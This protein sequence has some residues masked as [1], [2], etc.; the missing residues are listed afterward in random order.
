M[1]MI[2]P[3]QLAVRIGL[4][5]TN[6]TSVEQASHQDINIAVETL[7]SVVKASVYCLENLPG[8]ETHR[9]NQLWNEYRD[10]VHEKRYAAQA[11]SGGPT[12]HLTGH[13]P[14]P[15]D[16][17]TIPNGKLVEKINLAN[18]ASRVG[19]AY[20]DP[21]LLAYKSS[22]NWTRQHKFQLMAGA[23]PSD[24]EY[25]GDNGGSTGIS[26]RSI[27]EEIAIGLCVWGDWC[28]RIRWV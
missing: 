7:R 2:T 10:S 23:E 17:R 14:V 13:I 3:S 9:A 25:P 4:T 5:S 19:G 22:I 18:M 28:G 1:R 16:P 15:C 12:H 20:P 21:L 6:Q 24:L 27:P 8:P 11:T 26:E